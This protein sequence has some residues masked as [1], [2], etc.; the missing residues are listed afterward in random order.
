[1]NEL[2]D[3]VSKVNGTFEYVPEEVKLT[4]VQKF[5]IKEV[6]ILNYRANKIVCIKPIVIKL[7]PFKKPYALV[8]GFFFYIGMQTPIVDYRTFSTWRYLM[9]TSS[10]LSF[11]DWVKT[12]PAEMLEE[13][14]AYDKQLLY[15]YLNYTRQVLGLDQ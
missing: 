14:A 6:D 15:E 9:C 2:K 4:P 12:L 7:Q 11:T 10:H 1:M 13:L 5:N 3:F 8:Q